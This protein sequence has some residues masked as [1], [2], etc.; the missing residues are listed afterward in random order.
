MTL[1]SFP[2][3]WALMG[4]TVVIYYFTAHRRRMARLAETA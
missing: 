3:S 1:L 2:I 4:I